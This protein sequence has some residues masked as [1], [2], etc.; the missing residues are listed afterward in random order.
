MRDLFS[1]LDKDGDGVINA[2]DLTT[3]LTSLGIHPRLSPL[4]PSSPSFHCNLVFFSSYFSEVCLCLMY[5]FIGLD[6]SPMQIKQML[7]SLPSP[8]DFPTFLTHLTNLSSTTTPRDEIIGAF[9]AFDE[10]DSGFIDY[11]ELKRE[12]VG[13]G[14]RRMTVEEVDN[15]LGGQV[16]RTGRNRGR[17]GYGRFVDGVLGERKR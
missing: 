16:E 3:M 1:M 2:T 13:S 10:N 17:I 15:V 4:R 7:T 5:L 12:L 14:S 8:I 6:N 11:E 9:T